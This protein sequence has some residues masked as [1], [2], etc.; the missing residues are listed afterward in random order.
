MLPAVPSSPTIR[1][2][3]ESGTAL[4]IRFEHGERPRRFWVSGWSDAAEG[5]LRYKTVSKRRADHILELLVIAESETGSPTAVASGA[6]PH[7]APAGWLTRWVARLAEELVV[8]FELFDLT[9][10]Q[11]VQKWNATAI[12]LG[13]RQDRAQRGGGG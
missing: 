12:R 11:S 5:R 6:I 9:H 7:D 8:R 10:V 13:W 3:P 4:R 1:P 2:P